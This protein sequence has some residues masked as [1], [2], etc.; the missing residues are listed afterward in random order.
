MLKLIVPPPIP[1]ASVIAWRSEPVPLSLVFITVKT[2]GVAGLCVAGNSSGTVAAVTL[3]FVSRVDR[4]D[5]V[6]RNALPRV[7]ASKID[8]I[9]NSATARIMRRAKACGEA[10][11]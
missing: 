6:V 3:E 2:R 7:D 9:V 5:R 4:V 8:E 1:L 11:F 10:F